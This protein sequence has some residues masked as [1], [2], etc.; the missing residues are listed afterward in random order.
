MYVDRWALSKVQER[1]P[2]QLWYDKDPYPLPPFVPHN[3]TTPDIHPVRGFV[4]V[5]LCL[6]EA[7]LSYGTCILAFVRKEGLLH[8]G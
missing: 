2:P 4:C 1:F 5:G 8:Q 3:Q 7:V 6:R